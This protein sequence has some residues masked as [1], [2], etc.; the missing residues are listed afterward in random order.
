LPGLLAKKLDRTCLGF[1]GD[2][3]GVEFEPFDDLEE[4]A[5]EPD[6]YAGLLNA[7]SVVT[8]A[9]DDADITTWALSP[10]GEIAML[11]VRDE[12]GHRC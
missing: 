5:L 9:A 3:P 4:I 12:H 2:G 11:G 8:D 7:L 6:A 1:E 10:K